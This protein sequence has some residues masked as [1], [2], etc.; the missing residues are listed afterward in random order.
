MIKESGNR[1]LDDDLLDSVSGGALKSNAYKDVDNY[2]SYYKSHDYTKQNL[3][4]FF[5]GMWA[6]HSSD[7]STNGHK[8]DLDAILK[9]VDS[10]W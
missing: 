4:D 3:K 10:H 1:L 9:Y 5:N 6:K 8:E 7:F 2:I